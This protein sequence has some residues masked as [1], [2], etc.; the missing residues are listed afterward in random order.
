[1]CLGRRDHRDFGVHET[2]AR[3]GGERGEKVGI[4]PI[5]VQEMAAIK[6]PEG[7]A[8]S[9]QPGHEANRAPGVKGRMTL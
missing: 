8:G 1:M 9:D 2:A 7:A 3:D 6:R 4:V 5:E